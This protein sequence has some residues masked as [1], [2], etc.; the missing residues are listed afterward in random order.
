MSLEASFSTLR[1]L[2]MTS[3]VFLRHRTSR[4]WRRA[5]EFPRA[6]ANHRLPFPAEHL[7]RRVTPLC[8][9]NHAPLTRAQSEG[10]RS[11][12]CERSTACAAADRADGGN[13]AGLPDREQAADVE[14]Y[15]AER[16]GDQPAADQRQHQRRIGAQQRLFLNQ[17]RHGRHLDG[18]PTHTPDATPFTPDHPHAPSIKRIR[19][20]AA[21]LRAAQ[22]CDRVCD[23]RLW[24]RYDAYTLRDSPCRDC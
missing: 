9:R 13:R 4:N 2:L 22:A 3:R 5:H 16:G 7:Q 23:P 18:C 11:G 17:V 19:G 14:D 1:C 21:G 24:N 8:T 12:R 20:R 6:R 15:R 10:F